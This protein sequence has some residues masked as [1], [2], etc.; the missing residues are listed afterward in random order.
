MREAGFIVERWLTSSA[1]EAKQPRKTIKRAFKVGRQLEPAYLSDV[2][3][4]TIMLRLVLFNIIGAV[5][6]SLLVP[7]NDPTL[8]K[9]SD[10]YAGGSP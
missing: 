4:Q 7:V 3:A 9:G 1:G 8:T 6:V 2:D 10:T 5:S